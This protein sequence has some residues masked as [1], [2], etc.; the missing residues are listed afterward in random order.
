[1]GTVLVYPSKNSARTHQ[2]D[3]TAYRTINRLFRTLFNGYKKFTYGNVCRKNEFIMIKIQKFTQISLKLSYICCHM[4]FQVSKL[5]PI[6]YTCQLQ[7]LESG[8]FSC[9]HCNFCFNFY[10]WLYFSLQEV[11]LYKGLRLCKM[12]WFWGYKERRKKSFPSLPFP[13]TKPT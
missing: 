9:E 1:M 2:S 8:D 11:E 12:S 5:F 3:C 13:S 6:Y 4:L 7:R 10:G